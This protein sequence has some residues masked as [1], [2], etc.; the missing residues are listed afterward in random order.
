MSREKHT[1][2]VPSLLRLALTFKISFEPERI[3]FL[4]I[5][6]VDPF[7][8]KPSYLLPYQYTRDRFYR[9]STHCYLTSICLSFA[10]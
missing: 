8:Y 5:T 3:V 6:I 1:L 4:N 7:L 10:V 2:P 9:I